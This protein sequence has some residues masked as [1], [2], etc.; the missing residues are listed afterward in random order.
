MKR[1]IIPFIICFLTSPCF[2]IVN[3][4]E[5]IVLGDSIMIW[6]GGDSIYKK[7]EALLHKRYKGFNPFPSNDNFWCGDNDASNGHYYLGGASIANF[8]GLGAPQPCNLLKEPLYSSTAK[9]AIVLLGWNDCR[10]EQH[11]RTTIFDNFVA[12]ME[13]IKSQERTPLVISEW[14]IDR[15]S[16]MDGYPSAEYDLCI[17]DSNDNMYWIRE[18]MKAYC[19][20]ER[21][22]FFDLSDHIFNQFSEAYSKQP[23]YWKR[24]DQQM[25]RNWAD[26]YL[27]TGGHPK[28]NA[29][30]YVS[31]LIASWLHT[32]LD[33]D[34]DEVGDA[35]DNCPDL[36]NPGQTDTDGDCRG[37]VCDEFPA[38][39]DVNQPDSDGD[40]VGDACDN[41]IIYLFPNSF[42]KSH[43][44][45]LPLFMLITSKNFSFTPATTVSFDS[46]GI[47]SPWTLFLSDDYIFVFS[48]ITPAGGE[49]I[50]SRDI[51][52]SV[53]TGEAVAS[54]EII[55]IMSPG[56][57]GK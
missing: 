13:T 50:A 1:F 53:D 52:I 2:A 35:Y 51:T 3:P 31:S 4:D 17:N 48:M 15:G 39:Y 19:H 32:V 26:I 36:F 37:D 55:L 43:L 33:V 20:R 5:I 41:H 8:L 18:K 49:E 7:L 28:E 9:W 44:I 23:L 10:R 38:D 24:V 54:E 12:L 21:I 40:E 46:D 47:L 56:I 6:G 22:P 29:R 16:P 25:R 14:F 30:V 34:A 57:S 11:E 27:E 45:P 42:F